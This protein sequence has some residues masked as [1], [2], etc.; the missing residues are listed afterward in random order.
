MNYQI[1]NSLR[2]NQPVVLSKQLMFNATKYKE[3]NLKQYIKVRKERFTQ[4]DLY[5]LTLNQELHLVL[6]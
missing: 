6:N 3:Q 2:K 1:N 5:W 4:I